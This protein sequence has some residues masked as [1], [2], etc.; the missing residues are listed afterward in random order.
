LATAVQRGDAIAVQLLLDSAAD[1]DWQDN[2]SLGQWN[3]PLLFAT[4]K[5]HIG[6]ME[7]LMEHAL[8]MPEDSMIRSFFLATRCGDVDAMALLLRHGVGSNVALKKQKT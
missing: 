4:A 8:G 1:P 6:I 2:Y 5:G 7:Q 3:D